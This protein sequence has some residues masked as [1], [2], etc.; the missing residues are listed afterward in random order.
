MWNK[1]F[2][3]NYLQRY[4][5]LNFTFRKIKTLLF[6]YKNVEKRKLSTCNK[7][8]KTSC[9]IR[10]PHIGAPIKTKPS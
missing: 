9:K 6:A 4:C 10:H 7:T 3:K 2:N 8:N 5:T 1:H